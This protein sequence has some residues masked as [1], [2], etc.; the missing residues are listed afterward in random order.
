[1]TGQPT[2]HTE[3][4]LSYNRAPWARRQGR[5]DEARRRLRDTS[6]RQPSHLEARLALA[7][8]NMD[9]GRFAAAER[10][11]AELT[12]KLDEGIQQG[13]ES[14]KSVQARARNMLGYAL[15][16]LGN[17][18]AAIE[19]LDMALTDAGADQARSAQI[20]GDRALALGALD[21]HDEAVG[22]AGRALE[23]APQSAALHHILGFVLYFA[24]RPD[25]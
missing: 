23:L 7:S 12:G 19:V 13:G 10:D 14:L 20:L 24:G 2:D 11:L 22:E 4:I 21:H 6:R 3:P 18:A 1:R 8:I 17:H 15:Y 16:R 25:E 9:L 5:L